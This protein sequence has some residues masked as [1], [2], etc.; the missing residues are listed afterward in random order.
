MVCDH[1]GVC[2]LWSGDNAPS[3]FA[4]APACVCCGQLTKALSSRIL[5]AQKN[6]LPAKK[7]RAQRLF[8][9]FNDFSGPSFIR[10]E[11]FPSFPPFVVRLALFPF[12][13]PE[14]L[15]AKIC[16]AFNFKSSARDTGILMALND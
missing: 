7:L 9:E 11:T 15:L 6:D 8:I 12:Y 16:F 2:L 3:A 4:F 5:G 13:L 1:S 10:I 14:H